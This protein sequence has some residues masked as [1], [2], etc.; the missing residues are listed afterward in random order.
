M[1]SDKTKINKNDKLIMLFE[2]NLFSL[3]IG[4]D[5]PFEIGI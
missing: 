3:E 2:T 4:N 5:K 1:S